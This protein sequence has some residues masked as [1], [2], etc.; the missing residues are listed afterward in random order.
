MKNQTWWQKEIIKLEEVVEK[1]Q[2]EKK[3]LEDKLLWSD[4]LSFQDTNR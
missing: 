1:L 2:L 3:E 4:S